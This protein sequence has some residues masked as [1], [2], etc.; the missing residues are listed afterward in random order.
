MEIGLFG[1]HGVFVI[2]AVV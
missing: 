1:H 2:L